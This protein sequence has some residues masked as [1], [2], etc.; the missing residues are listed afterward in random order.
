MYLSVYYL[1]FI[2]IQK[3]I[4]FI[5]YPNNIYILSNLHFHNA[6]QHET[7]NHDLITGFPVM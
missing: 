7:I 1:Y 2:Q 4:Y 3:Y 6:P 5:K